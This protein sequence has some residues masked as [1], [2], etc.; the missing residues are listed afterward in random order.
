MEESEKSGESV[1]AK[2]SVDKVDDGSS[3]RNDSV[4]SSQ[5][6]PR[7]KLFGKVMEKSLQW[8]LDNASFDRFSHCFQPLSKQNPQLTEAMHKQFISQLQTLVQREI[9]TVI[10]EG[11][12]QVKFEE[13]DRLE[14]LAKDTPRAAWRPSGV[15]EQD[16]C[17]GLVSYYKKQEE[18][19][20]IQLKKLQKENAGLAQ[21]VQAGRENIT[22]TEQHIAAGVEEWRASLEDLEAFVSTLSPS[23]H[24]GSL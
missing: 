19:M 7:L 2:S 6:K 8:L 23:E 5:S 22:H 13:L 21:K 12:L 14:E 17:S 18:Y 10:E 16:V 3:R 11:D 4:K 15:P 9:S 24:F 1:S 20:R